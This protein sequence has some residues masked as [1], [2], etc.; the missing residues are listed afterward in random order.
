[1]VKDLTRGRRVDQAALASFI[2]G[3]DVSVEAKA[4]LSALTPARYIGLASELVDFL[5]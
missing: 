1:V 3:L 4:R 5:D 2:A